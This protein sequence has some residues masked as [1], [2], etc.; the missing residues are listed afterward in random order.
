VFFGTSLKKPGE[1]LFK[2]NNLSKKGFIGRQQ[3]D[4]QF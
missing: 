1:L 2:L 4:H 3:E